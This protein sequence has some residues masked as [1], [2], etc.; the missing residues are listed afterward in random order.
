MPWRL[1]AGAEWTRWSRLQSLDIDLSNGL[2]LSEDHAWRDTWRL[3]LGTEHRRGP[4]TWRAGLAWDQ[5]P[6]PDKAHRYPRLPDVDRTWLAVGVGY[7]AGPWT[8]SAGYAHLFMADRSG[9]H[10]PLAYRS[11]T[12]LLSV[13]VT[14]SW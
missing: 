1:L 14:R 3:S 12:D 2:T 6:V 11:A 9:V 13:G 7:A 4:W 10:P 8:L 5:S